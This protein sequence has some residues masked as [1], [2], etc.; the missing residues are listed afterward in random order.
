ILARE[1][2]TTINQTPIVSAPV[3]R[4]TLIDASLSGTPSVIIASR[5]HTCRVINLS[6]PPAPLGLGIFTPALLTVGDFISA[7]LTLEDFFISLLLDSS[8]YGFDTPIRK[9]KQKAKS[10]DL[11]KEFL[12]TEGKVVECASWLQ[13][14]PRSVNLPKELKDIKGEAD[15][16]K[17]GSHE[18]IRGF[19]H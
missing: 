10:W 12:G 6:S 15:G 7:G 18:E 13:R 17:Y 5:Y 19:Q 8:F 14:K 2:T 1:M 9:L 11:R 16:R 3:P 4:L